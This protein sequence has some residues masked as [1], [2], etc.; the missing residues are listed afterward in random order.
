LLSACL[1]LFL[2]VSWAR[3][4]FAFFRRLGALGLF[5]LGVLDSS[6]LFLPFGNDLLLIALISDS[7]SGLISAF[8]VIMSAAGS[9]AGVLLV[10]LIIRRAGEEG[11]E[12]FLRADQIKRLKRRM[13]KNAGWA[14]FIASLIPPP[15]PFTAAVIM[16]SGLQSSRK[17]MF[18]A[19]FTGR[20]VRFTLEALL[21]FYLGPRLLQYM[22]S[23]VVEYLVYAFIAVALVG[24]TFSVL[25]FVCG[26][27]GHGSLSPHATAD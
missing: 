16:A 4:I 3:S 2:A 15:F 17:R 5:L 9:V 14:L 24:S 7:G 25:K 20:L 18:S 22:N 8:Y 12:R 6:F 13:G 26:R 10:D 23:R 27:R 21:A 1:A 11:L 19:V